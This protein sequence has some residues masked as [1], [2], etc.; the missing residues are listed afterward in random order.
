MNRAEENITR[1]LR[2]LES[3][4]SSAIEDARNREQALYSLF[5]RLREID[6]ELRSTAP[7]AI[8]YYL[9]SGERDKARLIAHFKSENEALRREKRAILL[10]N[11]YPEDYLKVHYSCPLCQDTGYVEN[12]R[13]RCL[14]QRLIHLSY[15]GSNLGESMKKNHFGV[16]DSSI[17]SDE[18]FGAY[19]DTPRKNMDKM[20]RFSMRF[21]ENFPDNYPANLFFFGSSGT[22]K[23]FLCSCLARAVMDRGYNVLYLKA[24][25]LCTVLENE[26]FSRGDERDHAQADLIRTTDLL[27]IDDLGTEISN[28]VTQN[29]LFKCIE[30]RLIDNKATIISSNLTL[31]GIANNYSERM[32]SRIIG[33]FQLLELYGDD[34][35]RKKR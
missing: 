33:G 3:L 14:Q 24:D 30:Q 23:T 6:E 5:P 8:A 9:R 17:F 35:R 31:S 28:N 1:A 29:L 10:E 7:S 21:A 16:F 18:P 2:D 27:I 25:D 15:E 34:L 19:I 11:G 32:A 12:R 13:C 4:R 22:G 20:L 26:R